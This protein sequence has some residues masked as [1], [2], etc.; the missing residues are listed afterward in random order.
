[1]LSHAVAPQ[2]ASAVLQAAV[3]QLPLPL[4][5]QTI[6]VQEAFEVQA[7]P[8]ASP[9]VVPVVPPVVVAPVVPPVLPPVVATPVVPPVVVPPSVADVPP[10]PTAK[11]PPNPIATNAAVNPRMREPLSGLVVKGRPHVP[12]HQ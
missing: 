7:A 6:E 5:P 9:P 8:L 2:V 4:M 10:Q 3:Q 11:N 1:V 12:L